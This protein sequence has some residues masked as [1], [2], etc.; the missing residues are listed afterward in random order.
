MSVKTI[1]AVGMAADTAAELRGVLAGATKRLAAAGVAEPRLDARL[2]VAAAL[3]LSRE[4]MIAAPDRAVSENERAAIEA[5]ICRREAREPVARILG[6]REFWSLDFT[7]TPATLEPR[8]DS[9][10]VIEAACEAFPDRAAALTVLDIG[11]GTG[12][13]LLAFL[14]EYPNANGVGV[15]VSA[16]TV[17][18]AAAN[19]RRLGLAAR[20]RFTVDPWAR[21]LG[22]GGADA[23]FDCILSNP[24]YI[25]T[26]EL[27]G[28]APEI[29]YDPQAALDGGPDG[30]SGIAAVI[31]AAARL[32]GPEG[33]AFVEIG[34]GQGEAA[35]DL[36]GRYGLKTASIRADIGGIP[37]VLSLN[38]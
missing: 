25:C 13:L 32:L 3:E 27:A 26:S 4:A 16:D 9:E 35:Q 8:P 29:R 22:A 36:A 18:A 1:M 38:R 20:S 7:L 12:C 2:L 19:A 37:R 6:T 5:M 31:E 10:T 15:D 34:A 33:R 17:D 30:L 24:P 21:G 28:L 14:H 11:T 23:R